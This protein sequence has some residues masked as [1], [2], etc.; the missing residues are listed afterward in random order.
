[1]L[2]TTLVVGSAESHSHVLGGSHENSIY[3]HEEGEPL[4]YSMY[5]LMP[6]NC[7]IVTSVSVLGYKQSISH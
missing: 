5:G 4:E 7:M 1:M 6:V 3:K 2:P